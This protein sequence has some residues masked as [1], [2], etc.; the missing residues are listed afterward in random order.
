MFAL[1]VPP[2][3]KIYRLIENRRK[4]LW[5]VGLLLVPFLAVGVVVFGI[6]Q[7]M[8]LKNGI[9]DDYWILGSPII[10]T[11]WLFVSAGVFLILRKHVATLLTAPGTREVWSAQVR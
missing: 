11:L 6:L 9:L 5:I 10:V 7:A 8:V 1:A 4:P 2:V 3:V